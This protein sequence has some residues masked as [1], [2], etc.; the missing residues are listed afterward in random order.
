MTQ[1]T[2]VGLFP[3]RPENLSSV[4]REFSPSYVNN[5]CSPYLNYDYQ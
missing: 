3:Q 5:L 2:K 1:N 4:H